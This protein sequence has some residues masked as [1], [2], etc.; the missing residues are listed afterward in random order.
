MAITGRK[1]W[2]L[3]HDSLV[4][5][6]LLQNIDLILLH[7]KGR[8]ICVLSYIQVRYRLNLYTYKVVTYL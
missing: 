7:S 5:N 6:F 2:S 8:A 4:D 1:W 3:K